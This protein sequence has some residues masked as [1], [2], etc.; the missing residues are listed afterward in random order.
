MG[1]KT[2][3]SPKMLAIVLGV[4]LVACLANPHHYRALFKLPPEL[5]YLLVQVAD[6]W[7]DS[8]IGGG[9]YLLELSRVGDSRQTTSVFTKLYFMRSDLGANLAG[10]GFFA[11][12][13]LV[14][15]SFYF[16]SPKS[17]GLL[18]PRLLL[19]ALFGLLA[20]FLAVLVPFFA[21]AGGAMAILNVQEFLAQRELDVSRNAKQSHDLWANATRLIMGFLLL[22]L[23]FLAWPGWVNHG[24]LD[25]D[26]TSPR[27]VAWHIEIDPSLQ[28]S[29]DFLKKMHASDRLK[30]C[31]NLSPD[32]AGFCAWHA[33]G[34]KFFMDRRYQLFDRVMNR[35]LALHKDLTEQSDRRTPKTKAFVWEKEFARYR[36]DHIAG[37]LPHG[38]NPAIRTSTHLQTAG[39][40]DM[41]R[42]RVTRNSMPS[43]WTAR[44]SCWPTEEG[45]KDRG[46]KPEHSQRRTGV[47]QARLRQA[48]RIRS[49]LAKRV[50]SAGRG[51]RVLAAL[52]IRTKAPSSG[53]PRSQLAPFLL[54]P[55]SSRKNCGGDAISMPHKR[56]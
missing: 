35:Y 31:F 15:A 33:P 46:Q 42:P 41:E 13:A 51:P 48:R 28:K 37:T 55:W 43:T 22:G 16:C 29:A 47:A 3:V 8:L 30:R 6:I 34:L 25:F 36:I 53:A 24:L 50:G 18:L 17:L 20:I 45:D 9:R 56:C 11:L 52:S 21:A 44:R 27:R 19:T 14:S 5:G 54:Q 32:L 26:F 1:Q 2:R 4:G 12:L 7:P 49:A 23:F 39:G 38:N 40:L 10:Y